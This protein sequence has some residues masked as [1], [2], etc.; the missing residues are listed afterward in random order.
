M[1]R[2]KKREKESVSVLEKETRRENVKEIYRKRI[3]S[4]KRR[5]S[6]REEGKWKSLL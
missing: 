2:E 5:E 1:K 6:E 3:P 4:Y